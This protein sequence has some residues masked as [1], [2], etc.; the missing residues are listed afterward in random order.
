MALF[1]RFAGSDELRD[2]LRLQSHISHLASKLRD[3]A[4]QLSDSELLRRHGREVYVR[5]DNK[6]ELVCVHIT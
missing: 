5:H 3:P 6:V 1:V 2:V 4:F